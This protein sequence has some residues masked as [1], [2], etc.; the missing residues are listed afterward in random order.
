MMT[1]EGSALSALEVSTV[2]YVVSAYKDI[3][4]YLGLLGEL[5]APRLASEHGGRGR[6][7][8]CGRREGAVSR[9]P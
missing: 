5:E 4:S 3:D 1:F 8:F 6:R 9:A 7:E 2:G